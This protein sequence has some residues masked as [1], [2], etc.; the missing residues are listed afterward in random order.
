MSRFE[1][2]AW[3]YTGGAKAD[4]V[5]K[6]GRVAD[7]MAIDTTF[8]AAIASWHSCACHWLQVCLGF[9]AMVAAGIRCVYAA[10]SQRVY[11]FSVWGEWKQVPRPRALGRSGCTDTNILHAVFAFLFVS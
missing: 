2:G 3:P 6:S 8:V 11:T 4:G 7:A 1:G 9:E 10:P 5:L